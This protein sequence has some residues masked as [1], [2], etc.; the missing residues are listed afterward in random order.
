M[1]S[2]NITSDSVT[3]TLKRYFIK[4]D[5][6]PHGH[7]HWTLTPEHRHALISLAA[8]YIS[9]KN[10]FPSDRSAQYW[11]EAEKEIYASFAQ[12]LN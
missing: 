8:Y 4:D 3:T 10:G 9:E 1:E 2:F 6:K 5:D 7:A 11:F 12:H